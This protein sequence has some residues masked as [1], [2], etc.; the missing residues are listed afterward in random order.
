M[1]VCDLPATP[2]EFTPRDFLQ[3]VPP[4]RAWSEWLKLAQAATT[5]EQKLGLLHVGFD[6][7]THVGG[8]LAATDRL[9]F[10]FDAAD[11][12]T[13]TSSFRY[14]GLLWSQEE[15][16]HVG[17]DKH[18]NALKRTVSE[19]RQQLARK[20]FEMLARHYFKPMLH[21]LENANHRDRDEEVWMRRF[22][23]DPAFLF[24]REFFA[25][26]RAGVRNLT[27][28]YR[29]RSPSEELVVE[30]LLKLPQLLWSWQEDEINS[31]DSAETKAGKERDNRLAAQIVAAAKLWI[32]EVLADLGELDLLTKWLVTDFDEPCVAK[33]EEIALRT[34][35][36][37]HYHHVQK[38]RPATTIDE[39]C[40][41]G[42]EAAWLLKKRSLLV[43]ENGRLREIQYAERE[44]DEA[45]ERVTRL[46]RQPA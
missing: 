24:I 40:F 8:K 15:T 23:L 9:K 11:G 25:I 26:E 43:R 34:K 18:H 35:L 3:E 30:F 38:D 42:S 32:I 6:V 45:A 16:Y 31:Y 14:E 44:R 39:A 12:W 22:L 1:T 13:E 4:V 28:R 19:Q 5:F 37:E 2:A 21:W 33:L 41:A 7:E 36:K 27:E 20:A 29:D 10:Y 17:H 46:T